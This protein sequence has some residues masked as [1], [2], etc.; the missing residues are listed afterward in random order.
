MW[1]TVCIKFTY[2]K[3]NRNKE[4]QFVV[5]TGTTKRRRV[6]YLG[7]HM[8][9]YQ[10]IFCKL[11]GI[12]KLPRKLIVHH[13]DGDPTNDDINNLSLMTYTAHNRIHSKDR[14][15]WNKGL[16]VKTSKKWRST[17]DKAQEQRE[18]HFFPIFKETFRLRESGL[19]L[20][21]IADEQGI[22]RRQVS[23]RLNGYQRLKEKY[24]N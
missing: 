7:N 22:S 24:E 15:I 14:E 10:R 18:A 13:I 3:M 17:I 1:Y 8:H 5:T 6:Q 11:L 16:T 19:K 2:S 9:E 4:G 23:D 12:E 21:Q 20:Q